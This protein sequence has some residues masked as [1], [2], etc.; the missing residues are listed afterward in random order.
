MNDHARLDGRYGAD[1]S[2]LGA[3]DDADKVLPL[4]LAQGDGDDG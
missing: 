1:E 4:R 3:F 2:F